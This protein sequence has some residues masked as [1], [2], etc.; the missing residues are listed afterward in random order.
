MGALL[1]NFTFSADTRLAAA[2]SRGEVAQLKTSLLLLPKAAA[3]GRPCMERGVRPL[4]GRAPFNLRG[5]KKE[6]FHAFILEVRGHRARHSDLGSGL[7]LCTDGGAAGA[8]QLRHRDLVDRQDDVRHH[9][10]PWRNCG[11]RP[12]GGGAWFEQL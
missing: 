11:E 8:A 6:R 5:G 9:T 4:S 3:F 10:M 7:C 2:S 1:G 12:D